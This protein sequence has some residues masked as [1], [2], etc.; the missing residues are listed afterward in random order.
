MRIARNSTL[1]LVFV[2]LVFTSSASAQFGG[3]GKKKDDGGGG[4]GKSQAATELQ[5]ETLVKNF[6]A[7]Q[8]SLL[9]AQSLVAGALG[10]KKQKDKLDAERDALG[11]GNVNTKILKKSSGVTAGAEKAI[12]KRIDSGAVLS[13]E[14]KKL[15]AKSLV[16][17]AKGVVGVTKL[18][19]D[20]KTLAEGI[21]AQIKSAGVMGAMKVKKKFDV[22]LYVAPKVPKLSGDLVKQLGSMIAFA[23]KNG[24]GVPKEATDAI[25]F[26]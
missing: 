1:F 9:E 21:Q 6:V 22:G 20:A 18:V 26:P 10:L 17:Y 12:Q 5:Q 16:P 8:G 4:G 23:K 2:G 15:M 3:L 7:A 25:S 13:D 14:G 19:G 24:V 11:K